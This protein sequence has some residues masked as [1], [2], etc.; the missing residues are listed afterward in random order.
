MLFRPGWT[1]F[2]P[3]Q[4]ADDV[5]QV[6]WIGVCPTHEGQGI[7]SKLLSFAEQHAKSTGAR[8]MLIETSSK[9]PY[10]KARRFYTARAYD[11]C[12]HVSNFY[13]PAEDK[14]VLAKQL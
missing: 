5:W 4:H 3:D 2:S 10:A 12:G 1:Y 6:W 9:P 13:G 14:I 7:G 11:K 8:I